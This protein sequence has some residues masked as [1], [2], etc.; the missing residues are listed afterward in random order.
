MG[1]SVGEK[2]NRA[3]QQCN[4][5]GIESPNYKTQNN[6]TSRLKEENKTVARDTRAE[7]TGG[8]GTRF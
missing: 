6:T 7:N 5:D 2:K 8:G 4:Q 3:A 1:K